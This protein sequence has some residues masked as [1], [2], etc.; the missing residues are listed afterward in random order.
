MYVEGGRKPSFGQGSETVG[1]YIEMAEPGKTKIS[2]DNQKAIAGYLFAVDWTEK[3]LEGRCV[4]SLA[5]RT[6][7]ACTK[8]ILDKN[9]HRAC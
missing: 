1:V 5:S 3:L 7:I 9:W 4:L 2:T 8:M 6:Y